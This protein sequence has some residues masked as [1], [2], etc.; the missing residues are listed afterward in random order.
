MTQ[1]DPSSLTSIT[2]DSKKSSNV[3]P[4]E[5][6]KKKLVTSY[7]LQKDIFN[8]RERTEPDGS[9]PHYKVWDDSY[10]EHSHDEAKL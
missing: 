10:T 5:W 4:Y 9:K 6:H 1:Y 8:H 3:T 2:G 7:P